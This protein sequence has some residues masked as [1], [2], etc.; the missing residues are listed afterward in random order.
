MR[1]SNGKGDNM[2]YCSMFTKYLAKE[3]GY[4]LI[5]DKDNTPLRVYLRN[6]YTTDEDEIRLWN[7]AL[8]HV[9]YVLYFNICLTLVIA[10]AVALIVVT[11]QLNFAEKYTV[12]LTKSY[13]KVIELNQSLI[14]K[15]NR[16][17]PNGR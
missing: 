11:L 1:F 12:E 16:R 7:V 9:K 15:L 8:K 10:L 2:S 5:R 3:V 17:D 4:K 6:S 14:E 13:T